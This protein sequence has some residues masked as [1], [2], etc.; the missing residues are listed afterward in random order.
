MGSVVEAPK[1]R[2]TIERER[3]NA[4]LIVGHMMRLRGMEVSERLQ[5]CLVAN[6]DHVRAELVRRYGYVS[7]QPLYFARSQVAGEQWPSGF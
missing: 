1:T 3:R 6:A 5:D 2:A 4:V 7:S